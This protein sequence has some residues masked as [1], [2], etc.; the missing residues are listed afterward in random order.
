MNN[1]LSCI[2]DS[3]GDPENPNC[4]PIDYKKA[5]EWMESPDLNVLGAFYS[6]IV[7]KS[8]AKRIKPNL[9]FD[10]YFNFLLGYYGRCLIENPMSNDVNSFLMSRYSAGRDAA[11]WILSFNKE[12]P[13]SHLALIA[14]KKWIGNIYIN[15]DRAL[16]ECIITSILEHIFIENHIVKIFQDWN[17]HR[18][19]KK[20]YKDAINFS[21]KFDKF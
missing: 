12:D 2:L 3:H 7:K 18:I 5:K 6:L 16:R 1:V 9:S 4:D 17:A 8:Y 15:G 13:A 20:A 14:I 10:D 21:Q 19:L 11:I